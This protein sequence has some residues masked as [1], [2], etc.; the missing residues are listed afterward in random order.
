[1]LFVD[2]WTEVWP[3]SFCGAHS[4]QMQ[5][6]SSFFAPSPLMISCEQMNISLKLFVV[7]YMDTHEFHYR[8]HHP[9]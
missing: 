2:E 4:E 8:I 9:H 3:F 7:E 5:F 1:M 6:S